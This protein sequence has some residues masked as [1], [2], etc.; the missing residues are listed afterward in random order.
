M[1]NGSVR[2]VKV[3]GKT[4]KSIDVTTKTLDHNQQ[5]N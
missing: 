5:W 1:G 4:D 2:L 3:A